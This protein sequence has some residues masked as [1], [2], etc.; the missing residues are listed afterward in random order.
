MGICIP[1]KKKIRVADFSQMFS[2]RSYQRNSFKKRSYFNDN[3]FPA[4]KRMQIRKEIQNNEEEIM[5]FLQVKNPIR[6]H[7]MKTPLLKDRKENIVVHARSHSHNLD[8]S[9]QTIESQNLRNMV[10][11]SIKLYNNN[12]KIPLFKEEDSSLK[13]RNKGT[14]EFLKHHRSL[15]KIQSTDLYIPDKKT[16]KEELK[17]TFPH[18]KQKWNDERIHHEP[19][20]K[21]KILKFEDDI[22]NSE[23]KKNTH[24]MEKSEKKNEKLLENSKSLSLMKKRIDNTMEISANE[25]VLQSLNKTFSGPRIVPSKDF[26]EG[27]KKNPQS[28]LTRMIDKLKEM[29]QGDDNFKILHQGKVILLR[30]NSF[31]I[32]NDKVL[33]LI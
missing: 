6:Y 10:S 31:I 3:I 8:S 4:Q 14:N 5:K 29:K 11:H 22:K 13:K 33:K 17:D 32:R 15:E 26:I 16:L 12:N 27:R 28:S 24:K 9:M 1:A 20:P 21:K 23:R 7:H 18:L 2:K 30:K 19:S 25:S